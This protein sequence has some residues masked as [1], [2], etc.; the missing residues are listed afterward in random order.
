MGVQKRRPSRRLKKKEKRGSESVDV[1]DPPSNKTDIANSPLASASSSGSKPSPGYSKPSPIA[2]A[3]AMILA[4]N[5]IKQELSLD[6]PSTSAVTLC[7]LQSILLNKANNLIQQSKEQ[8]REEE[9]R[10]VYSP[11]DEVFP[12]IGMTGGELL[13][14][15]VDEL[16]R[17]MDR[18]RLMFTDT[19]MLAVMNDCGDVPFT[20]PSTAPPHT[21]GRQ[22]VAQKFD[23]L[24][25]FEYCKNT[26]GFDLLRDVERMIYFRLTAISFALLDIAWI[27]A[28]TTS[29][30]D[31]RPVMVFTDGS[32]CTVND[33][34][35]G[36]EDE[37]TD[38]GLLLKK[39]HK[40]V[41]F[42]EFVTRL[43]R[44][45][46]V[47]FQEMHIEQVEY[48]A[49]KALCILKLGYCE[50]SQNIR[51]LA[52]EQEKAILLGLNEYYEDRQDKPQRIGNLIL[53]MGTIFEIIQLIIEQYKTAEL[54]G[55]FNLDCISKTLLSV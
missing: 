27:T 33:Y 49:L 47:P 40:I 31:E 17:A 44:A 55:L 22:S 41:Y 9:T 15:Y 18:R 46:I 32:V 50:Y 36:W 1:V 7:A 42:N 13:R 35:F 26:P 21:M 4:E 14:H 3:T 30:N 52:K 29:R 53:F 38:K 23:H 2:T 54:F 8:Q 11:S 16:K 6:T 28:K 43:Y 45:V 20:N 25:A 19:Y 34:S 10:E 12:V 24:L 39:E 5:Q 51:S 48:A 37:I